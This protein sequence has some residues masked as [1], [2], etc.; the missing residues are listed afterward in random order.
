MQESTK[1]S[2]GEVKIVSLRETPGNYI[3]NGPEQIVSFFNEAIRPSER[4][5]ADKEN[6]ICILMNTKG[7]ILG[8]ET[9]AIGSINAVICE[10]RE[11]FRAAVI[12]SAYGFALI[13]NHPSGDVTPSSADISQTRR[14]AECA[15]L[16]Q[17]KFFD[18]IIMGEGN[19]HYS[20]RTNCPDS[21]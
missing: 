16:F 14:L 1:R 6:F 7:R 18:H 9:I 20:L 17:I 11:V 13:H 12:S 19:D 4:F 2:F 21:F 10:P 8:W 3:A 5:H 15:K